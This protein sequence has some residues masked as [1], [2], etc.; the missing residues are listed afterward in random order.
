LCD[1]FGLVVSEALAHGL[2]VITT[3]QVGAA[4]LLEEGVSGFV[5]PAGDVDAL[6]ARLEW[7]VTHPAELRAMRAAALQAARARTWEVYRHELRA[8]VCEHHARFREEA[9]R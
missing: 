8:A 3:D 6:A 4:D 9:L 5:L 7:C 1:G 2:P